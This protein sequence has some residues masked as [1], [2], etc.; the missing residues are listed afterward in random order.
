M[1]APRRA[2]D[3]DDVAGDRWIRRRGVLAVESVR[4]FQLERR[5][6]RSGESRTAL[7]PIV[8][9]RGAPR[10][11]ARVVEANLGRRLASR[12]RCRRRGVGSHG[13][14]IR[15]D[16]APLS[17]RQRFALHAHHARLERRDDAIHGERGDHVARRHAR[18]AAGFMTLLAV[19]R[20][21]RGARRLRRRARH[22]RHKGK[23]EKQK[24]HI[25]KSGR[26]GHAR[27]YTRR[28]RTLSA[29]R[30]RGDRRGD[31]RRRRWPAARV[32]RSIGRRDGGGGSARGRRT[33]MRDSY[34]QS[35]RA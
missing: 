18:G 12:R 6:L 7:V 20:I 29:R 34:M 2:A 32:R 21:E 23:N 24:R 11:P 16:R 9:E 33:R 5:H 15:R 1:D 19:R 27:D 35:T 28:R 25:G 4:P 31:R 10:A 22:K 26:A 3:V 13:G 30:S 8:G 17:G 14:E